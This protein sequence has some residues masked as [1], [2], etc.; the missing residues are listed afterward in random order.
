MPFWSEYLRAAFE[1][2]QGYDLWPFLPAL[3]LDFGPTTPKVRLDYANVVISELERC[4]FQP[5]F[6]WHEQ[7]GT[8]FGHDNLGR[9]DMRRGREHYGDYFRSMRWYSAPGA[10]IPISAANAPSRDLKSTAPLLTS[11]IVRA[12]G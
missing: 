2:H 8:L 3:W 5:I 6:Q 4:Y 9:G 12:S 1:S 7:H 10:M 11:I